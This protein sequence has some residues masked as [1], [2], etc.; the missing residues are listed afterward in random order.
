MP[1]PEQDGNRL[2]IEEDLGGASPGLISEPPA[3]AAGSAASG[4]AGWGENR[5][6]R[7]GW[8]TDGGGPHRG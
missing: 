4:P 7:L 3:P 6:M 5:Q 8:V 2:T 1:G